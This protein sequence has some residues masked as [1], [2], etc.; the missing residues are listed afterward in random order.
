MRRLPLCVSATLALVA[1]SDGIG[2]L[3][4]GR[5]FALYSINNQ[6]IPWESPLQAGQFITEGWVTIIDDVYADRHERIM[7]F[8]GDTAVSM[9]EWTFR[10]QWDQR[11]NRLT[12]DY[13]P[14]PSRIG[15][16]NQIDTLFISGDRLVLRETGYVAPLDTM[17]RVYC[18]GAPPC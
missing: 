17:V 11:R 5:P 14:A 18:R 12:I 2:P 1:C 7:T 4:L 16:L 15:P 3:A 9:A 6:P 8:A 10:G 13:G